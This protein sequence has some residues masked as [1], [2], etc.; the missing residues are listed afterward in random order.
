MIDYLTGRLVSV[1]PE[2]VVVEIGGFG[3]RVQVPQ[4]LAAT[5][6]QP[7]ATVKLHTYLAVREDAMEL[8]GFADELER[9]AFLHLLSVGG[10]GPRT[11][12]AVIGRLGA[13]RLWSA[14]LQEDTSLLATVPGIG[15]KSARRM[16]VELKDRLE[17]QQFMVAGDGPADTA[18]R[19]E[20][21]AALVGL[22]Y[23]AREA[24]E[25]LDR[26]PDKRGGT[27][28]LVTAAL[29]LLGKG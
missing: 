13:R 25:A 4:S 20:A 14:I 10:I 12:L 3:L 15:A 5:L 18:A 22:G 23:S 1:C 9:T 7:G 24:G 21:L 8:F 26:V 27:A 2:A 16:V 17:K 19:R 29:R 6:P 28:E 11:A